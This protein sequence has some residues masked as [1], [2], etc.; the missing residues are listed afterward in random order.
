MIRLIGILTGSALAVAVLLLLLGVPELAAEP[1]P[2]IAVAEPE[3]RPEFE[4]EPESRPEPEPEP[5]AG[6]LTQAHDEGETL[7]EPSVEPEPEAEAEAELSDSIDRAS[8]DIEQH[9]YAFW[10]PFRSEI[11]ADGFVSEL[12]RTTGLDYRVVKLKPG[13]YEVA[14]AYTD[15]ADIKDKLARIST[16]TGLDMTGG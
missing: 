14:F 11:A 4:P 12:A 2:V 8:V 15:D 3:P 1:E 16:A 7:A 13:I 10:S 9:W 6:L 5:G